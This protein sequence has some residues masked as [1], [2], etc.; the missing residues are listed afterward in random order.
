[1]KKKKIFKIIVIVMVSL[2][3]LSAVVAAVVLLKR[4][5]EGEKT[6]EECKHENILE[7][8]GLA[9]TCTESGFSGDGVCLQCGSV[10]F[11]S[12]PLLAL[13]HFDDDLDGHCDTCAIVL[14]EGR[15]LLHQISVSDNVIE[16]DFV[17]NEDYSVGT[18]I[19]IY[20]PKDEDANDYFGVAFS[21]KVG[22]LSLVAYY[23]N[24]DYYNGIPIAGKNFVGYKGDLFWKTYEDY[25]D[26]YVGSFTYL[27]GTPR[28]NHSF[29]IKESFVLTSLDDTTS[30]NVKI[31]TLSE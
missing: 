2:L 6:P 22:F 18:V 21:D 7:T 12:N 26:I 28:Q 15:A 31:V 20:R 17:E 24:I 3:F 19:R 1:M 16:T 4:G 27:Y 25:V 10:V 9:P 11:V 23:D 5:R 30:G 29:T 14:S 13:G 8:P